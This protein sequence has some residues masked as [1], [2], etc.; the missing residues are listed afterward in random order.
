MRSFFS[1]A[2][3][4]MKNKFFVEIRIK[5][6]V[7]SAVQYPIS[8]GGFMNISWFWIRNV[9]SLIIAVSVSFVNEILIK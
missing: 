7:K 1:S 2:R 9:K 6:A 3:K 4:R 5:L 8:S